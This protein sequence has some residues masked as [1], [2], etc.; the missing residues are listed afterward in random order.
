VRSVLALADGLGLKVIAEGIET[1]QQLELL[2]ELGC[3]QAQGYLFA[4]PLTPRRV[5]QLLAQASPRRIA[6]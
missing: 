6:A 4:R 3:P 5:A 2:R 1:R